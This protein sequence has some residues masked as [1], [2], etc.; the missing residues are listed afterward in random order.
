MERPIQA[1]PTI[2]DKIIGTFLFVSFKVHKNFHK[3][4]VNLQ[5][6]VSSVRPLS[7]SLIPQINVVGQNV[8]QSSWQ[9]NC[10]IEKGAK[11]K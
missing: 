11:G 6:F 7:L 10:S 9:N 5:N 2:L 4:R 1:K 3:L 8:S